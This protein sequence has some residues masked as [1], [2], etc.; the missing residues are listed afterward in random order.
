MNTRLQNFKRGGIPLIWFLIAVY[1]L[2]I[3][4]PFV[5]AEEPILTNVLQV[6]SLPGV[7]SSKGLE[8]RL[9]AV[10]TCS[11]PNFPLLFVQDDTGGIYIY[12]YVV[13]NGTLLHPGQTVE[14]VGKT[15]RG[16]FSPIIS[17]TQIR[18]VNETREV[19]AVPID[20]AKLQS[21]VFDSQ[22]VEMEGVVLQQTNMAG[23]LRLELFNGQKFTVWVLHSTLAPVEDLVDCKIKIRG[24]VGALFLDSNRPYQFLVYVN[25][26]T[27]ITVITRPQPQGWAIPSSSIAEIVQ[28]SP[29]RKDLHRVHITGSLTFLWPGRQ[30]FLQSA[31]GG[32]L[33]KTSTTNHFHFGEIVESL[34]FPFRA[35]GE[36]VLEN[37]ILRGTGKTNVLTCLP[38]P[39]NNLNNSTNC[40]TWIESEGQVMNVNSSDPELSRVQLGDIHAS[41]ELCLLREKGEP[42]PD[43]RPGD[44]IRFHGVV[45]TTVD[46]ITQKPRTVVWSTMADSPQLLSRVNTVLETRQ[47]Q[48]LKA[49]T[50]I[51][52]VAVVLLTI[53][54]LLIRRWGQER[55]RLL[56]LTEAKSLEVQTLSE[57]QIRRLVQEREKMSRDLHDEIIQS[58][59]A[60]GLGLE[61]CKSQL[62]KSP[63]SVGGRLE[64]AQQALNEVIR[65]VRKFIANIEERILKGREFKT[66]VKSLLLTL[67]ETK[68]NRISLEINQELAEELDSGVALELLNITKEAIVNALRH[69][70]A[71]VITVYLREE[72]N[73]VVLGIQDDGKGFKT[74]DL[75]HKGFGLRNIR[76]RAREIGATFDV[77]SHSGQGTHIRIELPETNL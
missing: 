24:V 52:G 45:Q 20:P 54:L 41:I 56:E 61:E 67:G 7:E 60:V 11:E 69:S 74:S 37:A 64:R 51:L 31:E 76:S 53:T 23:Q 49:T 3:R 22:Y 66:A 19:R 12:G 39:L 15:G 58:I 42:V 47:Q 55:G 18:V 38:I 36:P 72:N 8:V 44:K 40:S 9:K 21:G 29:I 46:A 5:S 77:E 17:P 73:R 13:G 43:F 65:N 1:F 71:K 59:Y 33:V 62:K 6:L 63:E 16:R 4:I 68:A 26:Q 2:Y 27:A 34:G 48:L 10:I 28:Y 14:V 50:T 57:A 35:A 70:A 75:S 30:L 32:I 25:D